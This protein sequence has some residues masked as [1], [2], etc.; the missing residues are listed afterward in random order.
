MSDFRYPFPSSPHLKAMV[1]IERFM[2]DIVAVHK[3]STAYRRMAIRGRNGRVYTYLVQS[4]LPKHA[5]AEE[6][7][8][9]LLRSLGTM[10]EKR[11]ESRA[12]GLHFAVPRMVPLNT[13]VRLVQEDPSTFSLEDV[14]AEH[15]AARGFT[16]DTP[17]EYSYQFRKNDMQARLQAVSGGG[18]NNE[19]RM[20][21]RASEQCNRLALIYPF[22]E[23]CFLIYPPPPPAPSP[24]LL[25]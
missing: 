11:V 12:R 9:Q 4:A 14:L 20:V 23:I 6:R 22:F 1:R 7:I 18:V 13:H 3:H 8:G 24:P 25:F 19:G 17:V 16:I 21:D 5:R 2:P 15:A 10:L